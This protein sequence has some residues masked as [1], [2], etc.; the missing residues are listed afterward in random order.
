MFLIDISAK[1]TSNGLGLELFIRPKRIA[2]VRTASRLK[3]DEQSSRNMVS[4]DLDS[5]GSSRL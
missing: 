2:F 1:Q 4:S 3:T 5:E